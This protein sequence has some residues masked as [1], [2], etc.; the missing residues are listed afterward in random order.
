MNPKFS[1]YPKK[2]PSLM[3]MK[4]QALLL[5]PAALSSGT[6]D[7]PVTRLE[8][9]A[10]ESQGRLVRMGPRVV[11]VLTSHWPES[12]FMASVHLQGWEMQ[13]HVDI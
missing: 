2:G 3:H 7:S 12:R 5:H 8:K 10:R 9:K 11:R 4:M 1:V 13:Q 6:R